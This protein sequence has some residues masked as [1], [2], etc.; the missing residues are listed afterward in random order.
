VVGWDGACLDVIEPLLTAGRLP[1]LAALRSEGQTHR[2]RSTVPPMSF[3]AWS[4]F[5]TGRSPGEHG[6]FD[7]TQKLPGEYR[8]R[9]TSAA[10]RRAESF[11]S[12]AS[13]SGEL[14]LSLGMPASFPPEPVN[15]FVVPG[16]D[17]PVSTGSHAHAASDPA[18]YRELES[19]VGPWMAP[20]LDETARAEGFHE[21]AVGLLLA[22]IEQKERFALAALAA[23]RS[24]RSGLVPDLALVVFS[25]SDTAAHH[26]WR[27]QDPH[28]PRH[29]AN[30]SSLRRGALASV[31]ERLDAATGV[32]REAWG[33]E[34]VC[35]VASDHGSGGAA[36]RV[37]H[38]GRFLEERGWLLRQG[39]RG[40]AASRDA[41]ARS[42]RD[43]ALRWLP[44]RAAERVFRR[45]RFAAARV[46]SAARFGGI[47]W[48][49][50]AAFT[51]DVNTQP[52]VW[53]N[54]RGREAE[55]CV[56]RSDYE[57][58]RDEVIDALLDWKL[59][60]GAQAIAR[61]RRRE[62][63]Y[64]GA[65]VERAPDVVIE[66]AD[67]SGYGLSFV[68]TPWADPA[69]GSLRTLGSDEL[70]GGR[71][72]GMNG[73]HRP[74]GIWIAAGPGLRAEAHVGRMNIESVA[75]TL[76]A[77][78]GLRLDSDAGSTGASVNAEPYSAEEEAIVAARLRALGY[79]V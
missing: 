5:A 79:L 17:A 71:G 75:P 42:V 3:P 69:S 63:V 35:V 73:T 59:P 58:V 10:D 16:F 37:L 64:A 76:L 6:L 57:R 32:L 14:V 34:A 26:Y 9:F 31:Y 45:A 20:G 60:G 23:L 72:R 50:S 18:L 52:G 11:L 28:S 39:H 15:G 61:A 68:P 74:D 21:R 22:R 19:R 62:E 51:E 27:D 38:L 30:A 25:E 77:L 70:G 40:S 56:S 53:I 33:R 48:S 47:D 29:D 36:A 44:P 65:C 4:S 2:L 7:F 41:I 54:L 8:I 78:R 67:D 12:H 43:A 49:R 46:E 66:A 1:N 24:R 55:G 13:R